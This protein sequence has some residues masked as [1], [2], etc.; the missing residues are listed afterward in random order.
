MDRCAIAIF[1]GVLDCK[2]LTQDTGKATHQEQ[3]RLTMVRAQ[4]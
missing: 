4:L 1:A 2:F 3:P